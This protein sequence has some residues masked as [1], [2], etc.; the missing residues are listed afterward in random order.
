[1]LFNSPLFVFPSSVPLP[2]SPTPHLYLITC[3]LPS[4]LTHSPF[5]TYHQCY[6]FHAYIIPFTPSP[7]L[8]T[9]P[10]AGRQ[11]LVFVH[12]QVSKVLF[13]HN[14]IYNIYVAD[15]NECAS[16]PCRN[17]ATC[18]DAVNSYTCLC[19]ACYKGTHCVTSKY[20]AM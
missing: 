7:F 17:G 16:S 11:S 6:Y 14:Y 9:F 1:M 4:S 18:T 2:H 19:V 12:Q 3:C 10:L 5:S 8:L 20:L 15:V 13:F